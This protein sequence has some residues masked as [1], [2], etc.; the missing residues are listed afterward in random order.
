MI[1]EIFLR[2]KRSIS[3][4]EAELEWRHLR[5]QSASTVTKGDITNAIQHR[6]V[7]VQRMDIGCFKKTL[8]QTPRSI[9]SLQD[10]FT[11]LLLSPAIAI[12]S[13]VKL[14]TKKKNRNFP[15]ILLLHPLVVARWFA[16]IVHLPSYP[17]TGSAVR[18]NL[19]EGANKVCRT[20]SN[21]VL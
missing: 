4:R 1:A 20:M 5:D 21:I 16:S 10:P 6:I 2:G 13:S 15:V 11:I 9:S 3:R 8:L 7:T 14:S 19:R 18:I 17:T 12:I